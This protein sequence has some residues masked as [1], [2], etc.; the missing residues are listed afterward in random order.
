MKRVAHGRKDRLLKEKR[1]DSYLNQSKHPEP[2]VCGKC[3]VVFTNGRWVW[4]ESVEAAHKIVCPACRR[5]ADHYPAG[6]IKLSG[7]FFQNHKNEILNLIQNVEKQ[8]KHDRP[9][10][11]IMAIEGDRK[12]TIVTTTGIHVARRI[13]EALSRAYKGDFRLTYADGDEQIQVTWH[14]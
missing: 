12:R 8:E 9:L 1:H 6:R 3:G 14:R 7:I 13:G 11:R 2:T 4:K 5:Q 10:E